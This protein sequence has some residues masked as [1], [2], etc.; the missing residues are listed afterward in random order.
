[1]PT[2]SAILKVNYGGLTSKSTKVVGA[3]GQ[4]VVQDFSL[5][6]GELTAKNA[7]VLDA[8]TVNAERDTSAVSIA[9]NEKR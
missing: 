4:T 1:M 3:A 9:T 7:I 8:F 2:G 5:T 6:R